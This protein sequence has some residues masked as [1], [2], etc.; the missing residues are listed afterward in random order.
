MH[1]KCPPNDQPTADR[2]WFI[3]RI[4]WSVLPLCF[5]T[6]TGPPSQS[7]FSTLHI[8]QYQNLD[9]NMEIYYIIFALSKICRF[10]SIP[11]IWNIDKL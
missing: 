7:T 4:V 3:K 6:D 1:A 5:L 8:L 10:H 11:V 9:I 2:F